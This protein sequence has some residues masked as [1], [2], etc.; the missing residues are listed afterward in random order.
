MSQIIE[1]EEIAIV[2]GGPSGK[3]RSY[4]QLINLMAIAEFQ[5]NAD[6]ALLA[7]DNIHTPSRRNSRAL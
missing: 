4:F 1:A 2:G 7:V 3:S 5:N 6:A